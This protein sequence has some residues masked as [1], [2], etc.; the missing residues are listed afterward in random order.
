MSA[1]DVLRA[2]ARK[3]PVP[4]ENEVNEKYE[5]TYPPRPEVSGS[6]EVI[7][8]NSFFSLP[9]RDS[10]AGPETRSD[11][12]GT[13]ACE[14]RIWAEAYALLR[15]MPAPPGFSEARWNQIID[16]TDRF[17][18]GWGAEAIRCGWS[19]LD[20]FGCHPDRPSA[21][22]DAMGLVLLL[23]RCKVVG[24]DQDGADLVTASGA[25]QRFRRR[26]LAQGTVALW[27]LFEHG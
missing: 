13:G 24:V 12:I 4:P 6:E 19:D 23:D 10:D 22:F 11:T 9:E 16:A 8:L 2:L 27:H 15:A 14:P 7:S 1:L 25:R 18:G 5:E 17:L 3:E 21:R 26:P 20:V